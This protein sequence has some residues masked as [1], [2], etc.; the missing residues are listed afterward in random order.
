MRLCALIL[1]VAV[2]LWTCQVVNRVRVQNDTD[3]PITLAY[4]IRPMGYEGVFFEQAIAK[5]GAQN[6]TLLMNPADSL[7]T[8]TLQPGQ[9]AILGDCREC[10][11][12]RTVDEINGTP[13]T[14][15]MNLY[16]LRLTRN[17]ITTTYT[18][19]E[20]LRTAKQERLSLILLSEMR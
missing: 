6:D 20:L 10:S 11:H 4:K 15:R 16:W 2:M 7:I 19:D 18:P 8:F 14:H 5:R 3:S 13:G 9:Q 17:G 12:A 1:A